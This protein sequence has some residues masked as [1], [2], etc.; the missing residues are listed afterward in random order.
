M[1]LKDVSIVRVDIGIVLK[2]IGIVL[3]DIGMVRVDI[4]LVLQVLVLCCLNSAGRKK[5][6]KM[7]TICKLC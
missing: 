5:I 2:D 7:Q 4:G 3:K 1:V 6:I